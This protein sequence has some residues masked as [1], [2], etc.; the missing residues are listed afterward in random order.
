[1]SD[2]FSVKEVASKLGVCKRTVTRHIKSG[3]L[4][5]IRIG[6]LLLIKITDYEQFVKEA[7]K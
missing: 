6:G 2:Y 3:K 4:P 1:M 7:T 5:A